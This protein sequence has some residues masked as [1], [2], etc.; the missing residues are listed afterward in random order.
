MS[1]TQRYRLIFEE[2][3]D[4]SEDGF[5]V[6]DTNGIITDI[7]DKYCDFLGRKKENI[8]GKPIEKI[9]STTSMYDVMNRRQRGDDEESIYMQPY[10]ASETKA[11]HNSYA[12]ANRFCIFDEQDQVIG[13]MAQMKFKER[14]LDI[15]HEVL[16]AE[17]DYYK[18]EYLNQMIHTSGFNKYL[19]NDPKINALRQ[20]GLKV[21]KTDFSVLITGE[22]GTGKE[23][24]AKSIHIESERANEPMVCVNC[25][26]IPMELMESE[27][28]GYEEGAFTSAKKGGKIGKF[29]LANHGTLFLDE[30]GDLPLTL[31]VKLL[32]VLQEH[33]IEKVGGTKPIPVD[34][35]II[36][37]T[38]KNLQE[39]MAE[40]TFRADLYYRLAVVTLETIPLREHPEDI[41]LYAGLCL[42][43]LNN[44]F[45]TDVLFSPQAKRCLLKY[46]WPGNVRELDNVISSAFISSDQI[47]IGLSDL[48]AKISG[49]NP[50]DIVDEQDHDTLKTMMN[51]YEAD[52]IRKALKKFD[53]N[54]TSASKYL[55][56]ERSLLYKKM[57]KLN[58]SI[59]KEI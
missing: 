58:I 8:L 48:P 21:A 27:M 50:L 2:L 34:V 44:K 32:R 4:K 29:Q 24:I 56:I 10:V 7:N 28:F 47:M 51:H 12:I 1:D 59:K 46:A 9:I 42:Q 55:D 13:A 53:Y 38:R 16:K 54:I 52:L 30:I 45:K 41:M 3:M 35:R 57:K 18:S 37:A 5:I 36:A 23:L 6:I 39:M 31:Q 43:A 15:A 11:S 26:A 19:G 40:G 25:G 20:L 17:H 49:S 22:T 14:S 33:E